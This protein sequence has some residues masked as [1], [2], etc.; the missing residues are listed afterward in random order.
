VSSWEDYVYPGT[1][2]LRNRADIRD[3]DQLQRFERGVTAV[4]LQE[5]KES[6]VRGDYGLAHMQAIHRHVFRDVYE[7]AGE[8]RTVDIAK[9]PAN[10]RTLFA[11]R[12]DIAVKA[13]LIKA[14]IEE[15]GHLR[16]TNREEFAAKMGEVYAAVNELHPFREGNGRATRE[17]MDQLAQ[18]SGRRLD[19]TRV[20][21]ETWK[22]AAKQS[23]RGNLEPIRQVFYEIT[24]VERAVAFD[25][26]P[27]RDALAKHPELDRAFK[28]LY[29]AQRS[30]KD[31][32]GLRSEISRELHAGKPISANVTLEESRR[33]IDHAAAY[34]GLMVRSADELGGR[35]SGEVVSVSSHH[36][37]L[38]VGDMVAVRYERTNLSREVHSGEQIS[39]QYGRE[40]SL[41]YDRGQEPPRDRGRDSMQMERERNLAGA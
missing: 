1:Q 41:V 20:D 40:G 31:V 36:A 27:Q 9:G 38:K 6:P 39:I 2:V 16:G 29:E 19:Y 17:F 25:K 33:V 24:S 23:A 11:L 21:N 15:S 30:N 14:S 34:R 32:E 22:E 26:L 7:W 13:E 37:M 8:M 3:P 18:E 4:R 28:A 12:E 35:F 10:D 5:L